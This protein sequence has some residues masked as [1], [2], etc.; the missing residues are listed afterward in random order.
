MAGLFTDL[1]KLYPGSYEVITHLPETLTVPE[2]GILWEGG[3]G[4][5]FRLRFLEVSISFPV[6]VEYCALIFGT[7]PLQDQP[8][9]EKPVEL[10]PQRPPEDLRLLQVTHRDRG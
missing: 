6:L 2:S 5:I 1:T 8:L 3:G 9:I 4:Y 10:W 7:Q